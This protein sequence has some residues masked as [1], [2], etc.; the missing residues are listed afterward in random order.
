MGKKMYVNGVLNGTANHTTAIGST[1][2]QS[3][4][5]GRDSVNGRYFGG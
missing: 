3:L 1:V 2:G 4:T 5:I